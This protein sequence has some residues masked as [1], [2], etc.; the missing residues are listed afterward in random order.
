MVV[1]VLFALF[2]ASIANLGAQSDDLIDEARAAAHVSRRLPADGGTV[3]AELGTFRP[4][5][6]TGVA[7]VFAFLGA[8]RTCLN[9]GV[10]FVMSHEVTP[11]VINASA[12]SKTPDSTVS[13]L[14]SPG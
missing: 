13:R 11:V 12:V 8:G 4:L 2:G 1:V 6:E 10:V 7:A 3:D 9:G 14:W 5:A